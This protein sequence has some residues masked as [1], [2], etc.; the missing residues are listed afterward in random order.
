MFENI[1][2]VYDW[3]IIPKLVE[4][5]HNTTFFNDDIDLDNDDPDNVTFFNDV[6]G[7]VNKNFN[8]FNFAG[9]LDDDKLD[10]TTLAKLITLHKRYHNR[11]AC[12]NKI[13]K[14]LM[15]IA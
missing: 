3:L 8:N 2:F 5:L 15:P 6:I 12:K 11:R 14:E 9:E 7:F 1:K 10:T 13:Y 4:D